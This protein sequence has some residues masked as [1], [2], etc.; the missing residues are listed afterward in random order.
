MQGNA[1]PVTAVSNFCPKCSI[2]TG[3]KLSI[4]TPATFGTGPVPVPSFLHLWKKCPGRFTGRSWYGLSAAFA[5]GVF[6]AELTLLPTTAT[7]HAVKAAAYCLLCGVF[8][9]LGGVNGVIVVTAAH[10]Q[11]SLDSDLHM[12][13]SA[14]TIANAFST[15]QDSRVVASSRQS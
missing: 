11:G 5:F 8:T 9:H 2:S 4:K 7:I 1:E 12:S 14:V 6:M 10:N 15:Q 13:I 3:A